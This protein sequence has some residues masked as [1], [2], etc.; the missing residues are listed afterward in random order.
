MSLMDNENTYDHFPVGYAL[1]TNRRLP[2]GFKYLI[3]ANSA[4]LR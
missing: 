4:S 1:E 2:I 3:S